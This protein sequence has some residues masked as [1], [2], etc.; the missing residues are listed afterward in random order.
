MTKHTPATQRIY[1]VRLERAGEYE[2]HGRHAHGDEQHMTLAE[3]RRWM[4]ANTVDGLVP[5]VDCGAPFSARI[6][7]WA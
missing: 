4:R 1:F 7:E 2:D 3:A 6:V 5:A